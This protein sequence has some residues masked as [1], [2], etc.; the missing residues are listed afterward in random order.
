MVMSVIIASFVLGSLAT[1]FDAVAKGMGAAAA[2]FAILDRFPVID[3]S[4]D[5]G[6]KPDGYE[7]SFQLE[8][9]HFRY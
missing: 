9:V 6:W 3:S 8:N 4:V 1:N 5:T 7:G 2:F